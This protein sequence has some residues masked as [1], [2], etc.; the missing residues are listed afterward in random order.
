MSETHLATYGNTMRGAIWTSIVLIDS[1]DCSSRVIGD[2]RIDAEEGCARIAELTVKLLSSSTFALSGWVG[3][4]ISI[5]LADHSSGAPSIVARLFT[6]LID[7]PT[8]DLQHGAVSLRCTDN[9]QN[10]VDGLDASAINA[11]IPGGY[12]SQAIFDPAARGWSRAQDRLSTL[13]ASLDLT[14]SGMLR[15]TNWQPKSTPDLSF[16]ASH[17]IDGSLRVSLASRSSL[18]NHVDIDFGYRYPRMKS[19]CHIVQFS[20]VNPTNFSTYVNNGGHF[21][22]RQAVESALRG[23]GAKIES[24]TYTPMPS[25]TI[26]IGEVA[27]WVPGPY[28]MLLCQGFESTVSFSYGQTIEERFAIVVS[29]PNS[30]STVGILRDRLSGA[31]EGVYPPIPTAEHSVVMYGNAM[32]GIPPLDTA[33]PIAGMTTS[34]DVTLTVDSNRAAAEAAMETLIQIAKTRIWASHRHNTVN[35]SVPLNPDIDLDKTIDIAG[36]GV[37]ARGKCLQV[38][39]H[40]SPDTGAAISDFTIALCSVAGVGIVHADTPTAAPSGSDPVATV[41]SGTPE[42]VY[43][44]GANQ[45][46][47]LTITFPGVSDAERN[48]KIVNI[49]ASYDAMLIEDLMEIAL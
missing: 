12:D 31:L 38:S 42:V 41:L 39:H 28:D 6:G 13:P 11:L 19:E 34:V 1:V 37:H 27:L 22:Q 17:L 8:L 48:R 9:L 5:D 18:I 49:S 20:Y 7:T 32:S 25:S 2:I 29:A 26:Y 24:I 15:L 33:V 35:A 3:K 44:G 36:Q 23:A 4:T 47:T 43:N 40:M 21:L 45:D 30:V 16:G 46:Q 10:I 14:P